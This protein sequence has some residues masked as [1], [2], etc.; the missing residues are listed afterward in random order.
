ASNLVRKD[1]NGVR[2]IFV[3]DLV[4]GKTTRVSLGRRG[5]QAN[6]P[7]AL[8]AIS[9]DGRCVAFVSSASNL[10][11]GDTN[12]VDDVFVRDLQSGTTT[13]VSVADDGSQSNGS[14]GSPSINGCLL[15][16]FDS[17]ASNLVSADSNGQT[18]VF[19]R[20]TVLHTTIRASVSSTGEQGDGPSINPA[21]SG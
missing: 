8:P 16:A 21:L 2:D 15:V 14:S 3:H 17:Q 9:G 18:D 4:T 7:S 5:A 11:P 20:N 12:N 1:T 19:V 13:R 10:V 6:G